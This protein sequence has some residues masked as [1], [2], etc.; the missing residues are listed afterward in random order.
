MENPLPSAPFQNVTQHEPYVRLVPTQFQNSL[1]FSAS[2]L[3]L[4]EGT[5]LHY[6]TTQR[7]ENLRQ[8]AKAMREWLQHSSEKHPDD[9]LHVLADYAKTETWENLWIWADMAY[10]S[11]SFPPQVGGWPTEDEPILI[12]GFDALNHRRG[13]PV[14]W[15]FEATNEA[16]FTLNRGC[17]PKEQVFNNYGAKSNEELLMTYGFVEPGGPDDVLVLS[18]RSNLSQPQSVHYWKRSDPDPPASFLEQCRGTSAE[19]N[20][21]PIS[22]LLDE[23][24]AIEAMEQMTRQ[25]RK[26]FKRIQAE[27]DDAVPFKDAH[28]FIR[29]DVLTMIQEYRKGM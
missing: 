1:T 3:Q 7:L 22:S 8:S 4:L 11:R 12:P 28:D 23:V 15:S 26:V 18:L 6:A 13:E 27:V 16:F 19:D 5:S 2:E 24:H 10:A 21:D 25:K 17:E 20:D 9:A 29:A 14:T